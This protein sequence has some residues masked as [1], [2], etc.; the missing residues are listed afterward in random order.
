MTTAT[1]VDVLIVDD[2]ADFRTSLVSILT[3]S[4]Y[5]VSEAEDGFVALERLNEMRVGVMLLDLQMPVLD[6]FGLL[7]KLDDPPPV[8][9]ITAHEFAS[10]LRS[11]QSRIFAYLRKPVDTSQLLALVARALAESE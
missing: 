4:G 8:V 11:H 7:D 5:R 2:S 1:D 9:V 3:V 6:G 10:E